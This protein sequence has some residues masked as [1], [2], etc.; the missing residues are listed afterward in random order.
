MKGKLL[1]GIKFINRGRTV[2]WAEGTILRI[3]GARENEINVNQYFGGPGTW[4]SLDELEPL[5]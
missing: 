2:R 1:K 3:L 5:E 4:V